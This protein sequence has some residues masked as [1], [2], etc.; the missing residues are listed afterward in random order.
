M[1][2]VFPDSLCYITPRTECLG[3]AAIFLF[4]LVATGHKRSLVQ[5]AL[6]TVNIDNV[7][8]S[9]IYVE[10]YKPYFTILGMCILVKRS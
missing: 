6:H 4:S 2:Y 3:V 5:D 7:G 9:Q 10:V 8:E 1:N